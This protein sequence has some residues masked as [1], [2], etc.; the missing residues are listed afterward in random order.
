MLRNGLYHRGA[1]AF[2]TCP[3]SGF[4]GKAWLCLGTGSDF[5]VARHSHHRCPG[6]AISLVPPHG[7]STAAVFV[8]FIATPPGRRCPLDRLPCGLADASP[9]AAEGRFQ[10]LLTCRHGPTWHLAQVPPADL[11]IP[12]LGQL[13]PS[14]LPLGDALEPGSLEVVRFDAPLRG[15]PL[16]E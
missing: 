14:Q 5:V 6:R 9:T 12:I 15:R 1:D 11:D 2:S 13:A 16:R 7:A 10:T 3:R 8:A 4:F